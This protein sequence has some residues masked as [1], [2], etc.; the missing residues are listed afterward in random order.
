MVYDEPSRRRCVGTLM[1]S[2]N[3]VSDIIQAAASNNFFGSRARGC[4]AWLYLG[5]EPLDENLALD[6][7]IPPARRHPS[8]KWPVPAEVFL[9]PAGYIPHWEYGKFIG[10]GWLGASPQ[11]PK[12]TDVV[13][14]KGSR[15][16]C[17]AHKGVQ[18]HWGSAR[19]AN[20]GHWH[21]GVILSR[22][23]LMR[24]RRG[25]WATNCSEGRRHRAQLKAYG[26]GPQS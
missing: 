16:L 5:K 24:V 26:L 15:V 13:L 23:A 4:Q 1:W 11:I 22:W 25:T 18:G 10:S 14:A 2:D 6:K 3:T 17:R 21:S 20:E 9:I 19:C 7:A 12:V 8:R